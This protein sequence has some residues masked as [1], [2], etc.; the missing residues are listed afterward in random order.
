MLTKEQAEKLNPDSGGSLL[1]IESALEWLKNNTTLEPDYENL[2]ALP[3]AA[4]LFITKFIEIMSIAPGIQS[5]SAEG[6]SQSFSS[7]DKTALISE[8]ADGL[9]GNLLKSK[10]RFVAAKRRW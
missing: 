9:L 6:L 5:E 4:K 10:A 7:A 2:D 1:Q 8:Y 3:A